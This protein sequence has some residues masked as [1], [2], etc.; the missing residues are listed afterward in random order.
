M[1]SC[2]ASSSGHKNPC[3]ST[4]I[5]HST[6]V[7]TAGKGLGKKHSNTQTP[8]IL[9][10]IIS[11]NCLWVDSVNPP[12]QCKW[13][14]TGTFW[15]NLISKVRLIKSHLQ[16]K[17]EPYSLPKTNGLMLLAHELSFC[18]G[19]LQNLKRA[20]FTEVQVSQPH[21]PHHLHVSYTS[22]WPIQGWRL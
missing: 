9:T 22:S 1:L 6:V 19:N 3:C 16:I 15:I 5:W 18:T 8:T 11:I 4:L 10:Q 20:P 7:I 13:G 17:V 2:S 21:L 12:H 14:G